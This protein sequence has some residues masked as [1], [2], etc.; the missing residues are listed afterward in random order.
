M[1]IYSVAAAL[2]LAYLG[3]AIGLTG[4]LLWPAVVV[5][6]IL[7]ALLIWAWASDKETKP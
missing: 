2:F 4:V 7:A 6:V 1:L 3:L 5:H